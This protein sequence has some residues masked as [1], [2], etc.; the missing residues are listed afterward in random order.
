M[1]DDIARVARAKAKY[2]SKSKTKTGQTKTRAAQSNRTMPGF[3]A[4]RKNMRRIACFTNVSKIRARPR[5]KQGSPPVSFSVYRTPV[6]KTQW[7]V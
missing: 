3:N 5:C 1:R 6:C 2:E 4:E 7:K